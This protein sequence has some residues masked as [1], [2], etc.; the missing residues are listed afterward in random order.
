MNLKIRTL[1]FEITH[2]C[3]QSCKHC[4][5]DGGIHHKIRELS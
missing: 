5:L 3:N 4:Y 2:G 1:Y